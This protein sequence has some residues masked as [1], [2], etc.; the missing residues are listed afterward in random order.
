MSFRLRERLDALELRA[1]E[2][3]PNHAKVG[4]LT[5]YLFS[6]ADSDRLDAVADRPGWDRWT[7]AAIVALLALQIGG[8]A[9]ISAAAWRAVRQTEATALNDPANAVAV[10]GVN[11]FMPVA[12]APY[13]VAALVVATV[14]HEGGHAVACR[15]ANVG[16]E[17]WGLALL[18]G[19]LPV[20]AYVLPSEAIETASV[21][22]KMRMY[23]VGV[24][25]NLA[26]VAVAGA[27]LASS[28]TASPLDAYMT[29]FGWA[30]TGGSPPTAATVGALG[31]LTNLS[32]WLAL[33][34]ANFALLN[35]L[36][37]SIFDGGRVLALVLQD[38]FE[39]LGLPASPAVESAVVNGASVVALVLVVVAVVGPALPV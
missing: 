7:D 19:V 15:R 24:F 23:A 25:H 34:N 13:V 6:T 5:L 29:Y 31:V 32:F 30:L 26:V 11:E 16:V 4:F 28:P 18:F 9:L 21:R 8:M 33:L 14:V 2:A 20:A 38:S 17:E 37:V 39:R 22:T 10:P 27:I 12:A 1:N 36:P 35:A 3:L